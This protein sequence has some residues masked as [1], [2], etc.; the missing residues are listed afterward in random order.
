[1]N[2]AK[3]KITITKIFEADVDGAQANAD[4][5]KTLEGDRFIGTLTGASGGGWTARQTSEERVIETVQVTEL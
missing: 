5:I 3:L 2:K 4:M 1:M